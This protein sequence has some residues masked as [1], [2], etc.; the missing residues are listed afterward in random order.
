MSYSPGA[1]ERDEEA[2][3]MVTPSRS[4]LPP[5]VEELEL[6][7]VQYDAPR[8]QL[9]P[10]ATTTSAQLVSCRVRRLKLTPDWVQD[11]LRERHPGSQRQPK[12]GSVMHRLNHIDGVFGWMWRLLMRALRE[13]ESYV[14]ITLTGMSGFGSGSS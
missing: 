3:P 14:I 4:P 9:T 12:P 6:Q 11:S 13:G 1:N 5:T 10:D 2:V 7:H 8:S